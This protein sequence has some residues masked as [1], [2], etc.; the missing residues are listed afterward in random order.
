MWYDYVHF[1]R[2]NFSNF[3]EQ[4]N[5]LVTPGFESQETSGDKIKP[6]QLNPLVHLTSLA[7]ARPSCSQGKEKV[8]PRGNFNS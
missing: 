8:K 3:K 2:A 1:W 7:F 6:V 5:V 4:S